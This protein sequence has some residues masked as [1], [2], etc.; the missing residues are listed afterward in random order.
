[1]NKELETQLANVL[2]KSLQLAE[3]TGEFVMEQAPE[4]LRQFYQWNLYAHI[5]G[6]ILAIV[7]SIGIHIGVKKLVEIEH[8]NTPY[9]LQF[10]QLIPLGIL[11]YN[12]HYIVY[13]SVAPK[14][15]LIDYFIK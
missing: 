3:N 7:I 6:V 4:L 9:L 1:M 10:F 11:S 15:Y 8:D 13:I 2:E 14:L 12:V 5:L